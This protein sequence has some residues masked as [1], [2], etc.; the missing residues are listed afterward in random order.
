MVWRN[1]NER[2]NAFLVGASQWPG[3]FHSNM[4][5]CAFKAI[6]RSKQ[7]KPKGGPSQLLHMASDPVP[8]VVLAAGFSRRLGRPK[9]LVEVN[10]RPLVVWVVD[11]LLTAG[12]LPVVVVNADIEPQ[13]R[14]MVPH[15]PIVVNEDPDAGRTG[16]LHV[17]PSAGGPHI[18]S[19]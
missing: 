2:A 10:G 14:S 13:V 15:A 9:A 12:C 1:S 16:S 3:G 8:A 4:A 5:V 18:P 6:S 17:G 19:P 7:R 11:R